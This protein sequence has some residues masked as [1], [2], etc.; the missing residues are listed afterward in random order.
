M[1]LSASRSN[2]AARARCEFLAFHSLP[3]SATVFVSAS[4]TKTGS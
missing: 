1:D 4:G 2:C 3:S